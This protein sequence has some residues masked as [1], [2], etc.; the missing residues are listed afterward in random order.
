IESSTVTTFA[1]RYRPFDHSI[2][3]DARNLSRKWEI[4]NHRFG[5]GLAGPDVAEVMRL[6]LQLGLHGR[7]LTNSATVRGGVKEKWTR[8]SAKMSRVLE[9]RANNDPIFQPAAE[10]SCLGQA[11]CHWPCPRHR[12]IH[13]PRPCPRQKRSPSST[14]QWRP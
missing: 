13:P 9:G 3:M 14:G 1:A 11:S 10:F 4:A 12:K 2:R 6:R 7:I 5:M 8:P